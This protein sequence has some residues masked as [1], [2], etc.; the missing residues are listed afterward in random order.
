MRDQKEN[1]HLETSISVDGAPIEI[2][3]GSTEEHQRTLKNCLL[4]IAQNRPNW[5]VWA[6]NTGAV[7]VMSGRFIRFGLKGSSDIVGID[8]DGKFIA[9]EVKTG[10][11]VQSTQ[12][13][14]FMK[15]ITERGGRFYLVRK[16]QSF[17]EA[18]KL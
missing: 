15:M 16:G 10:K 17:E 6:N 11:A 13:K 12:Q 8:E 2:P 1:I 4:W 18:F 14:M 9:I 5:R 3:A 7:K